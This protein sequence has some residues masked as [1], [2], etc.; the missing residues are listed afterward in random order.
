MPE[1]EQ[2]SRKKT[3]QAT[4]RRLLDAAD[5]L[6][7]TVGPAR[8]SLEAVATE[9]GVSKGGLLYHFPSKHHLLRAL[10]DD[11]VQGMRDEMQR[12]APGCFD[13]DRG[14]EQALV[15]ARA[16][17]QMMQDLLRRTEGYASG[18]FAALAEDPHFIAPLLE[19]RA[20]VR[21]LFQR[22]PAPDLAAVVHLA[23]EGLV[24]R[25]LTAPEDWDEAEAEAR[26]AT[27]NGM[28]A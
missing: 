11:H 12:L 19:F 26:F 14:P 24:H 17:L 9:A 7:R 23:C 18:V 3:A 15:G 10:V 25:R 1:V 13:A 28:L 27:L 21:A 16:Y 4:R 6:S 8:L 22:C 5:Q 20:D 2:K